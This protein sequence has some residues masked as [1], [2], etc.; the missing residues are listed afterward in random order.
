[1]VFKLATRP[2]GDF[3]WVKPGKAAWEW[4]HAWNLLGVDFK[5]GIN[6]ETYK[7]YI[8][9]ASRYGVEYILLDDGWSPKNEADLF[10]VV[11]EL[12]L[13]ELVRYGKNGM[14][15]LFFGQ[16]TILSIG[17]WKVYASIIL[18]WESKVLRWIIWK[19]MTN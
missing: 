15:D 19:G 12:D 11:P 10:K 8:D 3:S 1:M 4:W 16:A 17:I 7:C 6:N 14:W 2:Q 13:P 9:F 18:K 5:T